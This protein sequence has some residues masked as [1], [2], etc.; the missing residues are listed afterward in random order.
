MSIPIGSTVVVQ[1][2]DEGPWTHG[3]V[4]DKGDYNHHNRSYKIQVTKT[5]RIITHNRQHIRPTPITAENFLHNQLSKHTKT[6]PLDAILDHIQRH[7]P[8]HTIKN[9][10]NE[11]ANSNIM[12]DAQKREMV[13]KTLKEHKERKKT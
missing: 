1:P 11:R 9:I 2:E 4:V 3:A 13:H 8:P 10:T 5:G 6:D 12:P 7:P